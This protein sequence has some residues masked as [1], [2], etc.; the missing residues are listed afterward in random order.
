MP[1]DNLGGP[2]G[3]PVVSQSQ[4]SSYLVQSVSMGGQG[5]DTHA[6]S[7]VSGGVS[8]TLQTKMH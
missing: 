4:Q 1:G 6:C 7:Q 3:G 2:G 8:F 5:S